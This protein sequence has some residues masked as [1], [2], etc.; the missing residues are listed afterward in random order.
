M[1]VILLNFYLIMALAA[2]DLQDSEKANQWTFS[3]IIQFS[4]DLLITQTIMISIK[5]IF[6]IFI[7]NRKKLQ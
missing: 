7:H 3:F 5:Y 1:C 2:L 6:V 4:T